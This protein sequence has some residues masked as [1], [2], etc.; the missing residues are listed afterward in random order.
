MC[1]S[2]KTFATLIKVL[3]DLVP[4]ESPS[5]L[6]VHILRPPFVPPK[7][8]ELLADYVILAKTRLADLKVNLFLF[9]LAHLAFWAL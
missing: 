9:F 3:T 7:C 6:K 1:T 2:K 5:C 4:F 8:K